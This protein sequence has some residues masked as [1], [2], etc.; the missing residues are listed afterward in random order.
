[1]KVMDLIQY[2][3]AKH[4]REIET[5]VLITGTEDSID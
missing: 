2:I 5:A 3:W 4:G 1:M